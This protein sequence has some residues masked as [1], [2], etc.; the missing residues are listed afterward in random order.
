MNR[1]TEP[2]SE[3]ATQEQK[4]VAL[5]GISNQKKCL[6]EN[7]IP[8][9]WFQT[10]VR[11]NLLSH[12]SIP[13][14][15]REEWRVANTKNQTTMQSAYVFILPPFFL[16]VLF[17]L[18]KRANLNYTFCKKA[19][20]LL[21]IIKKMIQCKNMIL[22]IGLGNPG[23][24]FKNTRHNAGFMV[25]DKFAKEN[26][27]PEFKLQKKYDSLVSENVVNDEKTILAKPQTFM[28]DSG[29][30][31]KY[32][33]KSSTRPGLIVIHDDIDLPLGKI[34]IVKDRGSAGHKGV[35]SIIK[36]IGAKNFIRLRIGIQPKQSRS[37]NHGTE[38]A[39][40]IVL[41]KFTKE[42]QKI[43]DE[44]IDKAAES[45]DFLLKEGLDKAM[46]EYNK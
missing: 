29:K 26:N 36:N 4:V 18:E 33:L 35:E 30:A 7:K 46:N 23:E 37:P 16:F 5:R 21:K 14:I 42:E 9:F 8:V 15:P 13:S 1:N 19:C 6:F 24:K 20:Q 25:L 44:M 45:L 32:L 34:K 17:S 22:I 10:A 28:N 40:E 3:N 2:L 27:F 39:K 31:A 12:E 11:A 41:K 38:K 43:I